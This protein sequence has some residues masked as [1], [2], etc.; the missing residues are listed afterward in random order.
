MVV[1]IDLTKKTE[2][3]DVQGIAKDSA[4]KVRAG[5]KGF[6][7]FIFFNCKSKTNNVDPTFR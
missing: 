6:N 5:F 4:V 7:T 1:D 3:I 2:I